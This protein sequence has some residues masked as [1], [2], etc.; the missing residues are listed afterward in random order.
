MKSSLQC[1][2]DWSDSFCADSQTVHSVG[3]EKFE[4]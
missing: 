4:R 1:Q 3:T 2:T